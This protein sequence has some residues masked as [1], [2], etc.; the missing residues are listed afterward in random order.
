MLKSAKD[1]NILTARI[2]PLGHPKSSA[3]VPVRKY[4]STHERRNVE[5]R[6]QI[7]VPRAVVARLSVCPFCALLLS[8]RAAERRHY[9]DA[10]IAPGNDNDD[11]SG[12]K[13]KAAR[14]RHQ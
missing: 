9:H 13:H 10:A 1:A 2:R 7:R 6:H 14:A 12:R 8:E 4:F 5:I 11:H 3:P